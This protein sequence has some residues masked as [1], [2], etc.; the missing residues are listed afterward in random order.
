MPTTIAPNKFRR[1]AW[2]PA[3]AGTTVSLLIQFSNSS[4]KITAVIT[5]EG[6]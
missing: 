1:G 5:R 3:C 4:S 2:V 6:G